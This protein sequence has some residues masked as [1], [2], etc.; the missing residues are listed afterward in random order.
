MTRIPLASALLLL[1]TPAAA[2]EPYVALQFGAPVWTCQTNDCELEAGAENYPAFG[3]A[4]GVR[5]PYVRFEVEAQSLR[6][7]VHGLNGSRCDDAI[8]HT[9]RHLAAPCQVD[10][11]LRVGALMVNAWPELTLLPDRLRVYAGGGV[12]MLYLSAIDHAAIT[13]GAQAGA[14]LD[15]R[16]WRR[17]HI[18]FGYKA[19][20]ALETRQL[21]GNTVDFTS[22]GPTLRLTWGF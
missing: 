10:T 14:G 1:A 12:G 11:P 16:V 22:H 6:F 5:L 3:V 4:V 9:P 21:D 19:M 18:D 7:E 2:I 17:L 8:R 13:P 20:F 15:V